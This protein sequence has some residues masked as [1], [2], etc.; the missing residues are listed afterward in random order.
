MLE[1][2][3]EKAKEEIGSLA[4]DDEDLIV[5]ALFPVTG[6]KY[7][8]QKY[9]KEQVPES[10]KA[11][12]LEDVAKQDAMVAKLKKGE[13][14]EKTEL[15]DIPEIY[16]HHEKYKNIALSKGLQSEQEKLKYVIKEGIWE[17]KD[18]LEINIIGN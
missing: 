11:I 15:E 17:S 3:L 7:L 18:D 6:K 5:Y 10:V 8:M 12:T 16:H 9:G 13:L 2:E 14:I 4:V 1:P